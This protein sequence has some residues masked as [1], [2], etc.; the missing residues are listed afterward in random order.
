[1]PGEGPAAPASGARGGRRGPE[2]RRRI[3][4]RVRLNRLAIGG[5]AGQVLFAA[6]ELGVFDL[7]SARGELSA[8][9]LAAG[10]GADADATRRLLGALVAVDLVEHRGE[11]FA[12]AFAA[13]EYLVSGRPE[14]LATWVSL[15]GRW[16]RTFSALPQSVRSGQPAEVPEE[17]LG[18]SADYT[19]DF[20]VGMHDYA[21]GPGRELARYLD[22]EGRERLLDVG[23]GPG[24]YS[25]LL[26]HA[27]PT[28]RCVVF[29][30]KEVVAI[31][32][33]IVAEEELGERISTTAGDYHTDDFPTGFDSVLV[34]NVLHQEDWDTCRQ[35]LA[36]AHTSLQPG[37]LVVVHAM[38]LNE[39]GDGPLWPALHNLLM[40]LVYRGGRAYSVEQTYQMLEEAGFSDPQIHRMSPFNAGSF[41][42]ALRP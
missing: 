8:D 17:H 16:N 39:R 6:N 31:A 26:A 38:F 13:Q 12:N 28:L 22:L 9:E 2:R 27:N 1:M 42:T 30:L 34:S 10:L 15:I 33:E 18:R 5:W 40:L 32:E 7:L 3:A 25:I 37:G 19:R 24:T 36:K 20:I 35:I 4:E 23:G 21:I 11:R 41:V 14:S 29:D